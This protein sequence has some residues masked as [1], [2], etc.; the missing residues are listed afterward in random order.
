[1]FL[2]G[3]EN[4]G[5]LFCFWLEGWE[6]KFG[7]F[8]IAIGPQLSASSY[9]SSSPLTHP[10]CLA[11]S[12]AHP[13]HGRRCPRQG[14]AQPP[15]HT[16][17]PSCAPWPLTPVHAVRPTPAKLPNDEVSERKQKTHGH[18]QGWAQLPLLEECRHTAYIEN[19]PWWD[20]YSALLSLNQTP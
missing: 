9:S 10:R 12:P 2:F 16:G 18:D 4:E 13:R 8:S 11:S 3:W 20:D 5:A 1:M 14:A 19:I 17:L 15:C 7:P 6:K